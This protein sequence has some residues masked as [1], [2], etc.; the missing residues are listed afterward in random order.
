MF[1]DNWLINPIEQNDKDDNNTTLWK[2]RDIGP[3]D[4]IFTELPYNSFFTNYSDFMNFQLE[5]S[6]P[7]PLYLFG[8]LQNKVDIK[9]IHIADEA[10][11]IYVIREGFYNND[12]GIKLSN[13]KDDNFL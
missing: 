7:L 5:K 1:V 2:S 3:Q 13:E 12:I 8:K 11:K 9:T 6:V 10:K 4:V